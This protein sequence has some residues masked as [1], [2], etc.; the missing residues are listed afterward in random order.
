MSRPRKCRRIC[1]LPK[2]NRFGPLG[3]EAAPLEPIILN[4]DEYETI[5]LIDLLGLTQEECALQM[6]VARTTVQ[7]IYN[8]ARGKLARALVEGKA[9]H[10][11]GGDYTLCGQ[12][13]SCCGKN[14]NRH[15]CS[16][17]RCS[18]GEQGC[19]LSKPTDKHGGCRHEN[20][21]HL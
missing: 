10:I 1:V 17:K 3:A 5:R 21:S 19:S 2:N 16:H 9:L 4:L 20:C 18:G 6:D 13:S 11:E 12:S 15:G 8:T 14:C 7:A